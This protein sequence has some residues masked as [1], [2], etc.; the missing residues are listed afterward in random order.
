MSEKVESEVKILFQNSNFLVVDKPAGLVV[1]ADGRTSEPSLV[2]WIKLQVTEG[3]LQEGQENIGRPHTLDSGRYVQRWGIVNRLDRETSGLILIAKNTE[4]FERLQEKFLKRE[5]EKKYEATLWGEIGGEEIKNLLRDKKIFA[6]EKENIYLINEGLTRHKKDPRVWVCESDESARKS[7][8]G[9]QTLVEFIKVVD[10]NGKKFTTV[11][12]FPLTGRTHQLRLHA[13][14]L[15]HP[16]LGDK[17]YSFGGVDNCWQ[18]DKN[19][20]MNLCAVGLGFEW[21]GEK[22]DFSVY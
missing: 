10:V 9:A 8:R 3:K 6:T 15:G 14:F 22:F 19:I 2:D 5:I 21:N 11:N 20:L 13:K 18:E 7:V 12:F 17:K 16:I 1:H 4:T